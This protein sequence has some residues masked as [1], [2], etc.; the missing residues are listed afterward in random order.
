MSKI[1]NAIII[2]LFGVVCFSAG[3]YYSTTEFEEQ[4]NVW[5]SNY[6]IIT[7]KVYA[8]EKVSDPKT[9]RLYVK[10][11]NKLLDDM[12]RLG[13]I[14]DGGDELE[15]VLTNY[16]KEYGRLKNKVS[17]VLDEFELVEKK[18]INHDITLSDFTD[19]NMEKI[20]ELKRKIEQQRQY[21]ADVKVS[22]E[23]KVKDIES[24][25]I[26]IKDSKYG[27]KIWKIKK[28]KK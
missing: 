15:I 11:L 19:V 14:I 21:T 26:I 12:N 4:V 3:I 27:K 25:V 24:D 23:A 16:E 9:I 6:Q 18:L 10:E 17:D 5:D 2:G 13:N 7:D 8:F 20:G 28:S 22:L 1:I